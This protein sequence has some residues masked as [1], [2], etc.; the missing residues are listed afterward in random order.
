MIAV[1]ATPDP[2]LVLDRNEVDA[3]GKRTRGAQ[4]VLTLVLANPVMD[5]KRVASRR[6][7]WRMQD[8]DLAVVGCRR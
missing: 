1:L 6:L 2:V 7:L 5:F 3:P 4:V 8:D